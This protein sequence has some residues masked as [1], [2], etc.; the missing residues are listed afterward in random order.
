[1][2]RILLA[3]TAVTVLLA[4]QDPKK[5]GDSKQP[6][7][8][9]TAQEKGLVGKWQTDSIEDSGAKQSA[10]EVKK[11]SLELNGDG[12]FTL[13]FTGAP[14]EKSGKHKGTVKFNSS[15]S[16]KTIE[17]TFTDGPWKGETFEGIYKLEGDTYTICY[18]RKGQEAPK[19]FATKSEPAGQMLVV[20]KRVKAG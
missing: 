10:D 5:P 9:S 8:G 13:I 1:M 17:F 12:T 15:A 20:Y 6:A 18:T 4:A 2:M 11:W 19:T 7:A 3:L 14:N 16:P